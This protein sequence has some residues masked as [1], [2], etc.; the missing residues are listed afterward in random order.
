MTELRGDVVVLRP[1]AFE[2]APSLRAIHVRPEVAEWWGTM[3]DAFPFDEPE[4]TRFTVLV[5]DRIAG[6]VQF[7]EENE[8]TYRHAW[9]DIFIDPDLHGRGV[10]SDAVARL[11]AYL[12]EERGHHRITIDP[13]V[14]NV[15]AVRA[16]E[17]AGFQRVGVMQAAE[18]D[19]RGAWRDALLMEMVDPR[20]AGLTSGQASP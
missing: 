19:P 4:S 12:L 6:L 3:E 14:D 10:G 11:A 5:D 20:V 2:D 15:K 1:L 17:K 16:Y 8:A 13:T 9:I 7:G 18:R